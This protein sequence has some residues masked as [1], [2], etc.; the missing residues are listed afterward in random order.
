MKAFICVNSKKAK[1]AKVCR[2]VI[3]KLVSLNI[4]PVVKESN[5]EVCGNE[6]I[7]LSDTCP[8]DADFII[9][10]GG[11]G[12]M[13]HSGVMAAERNIPMLGVNTGRLGFM[14]TLESDELKLLEKLVDNDYNISE[15]MMFDVI[16]QKDNTTNEYKALNDVV[17]A[18][19]SYSKLP[20]FSVTSNDSV[21]LRLRSDGVIVSTPT[22]STAYSLSAGGPIIEPTL[23]CI[24][25]TALCP[26]TVMNRPML[27]DSE[28]EL[29]VS[30]EGYEGSRV[31]ISIDGDEIGE[32]GEGD[33]I[34]IRKSEL[35]LR[36]I[37]LKIN[38]FYES[39]H[40]KLMQPLK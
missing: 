33:K 12:T 19:P 1:S 20:E 30:F 13:L 32:I 22:G 7:V 21:V 18:K 17:L 3:D 5:M 8:H 23:E 38:S 39:I 35:R 40:R 26:H 9:T 37:D 15:R 2:K 27:F 4:V 16:I 6:G 24:E 14:T 11:D 31:Y 29:C 28:N 36:L 34:I 10:V 25:L